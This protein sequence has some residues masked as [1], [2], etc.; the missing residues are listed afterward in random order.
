M[1]LDN[2]E[3]AKLKEL[4][5]SCIWHPCTQMHDHEANIPLIPIA[6]AQG[7]YLYDFENRAYLDCVSSWWVN[8]F[9]H[10]NPYISAKL[11]EQLD[12]LEHIIL[13]VSRTSPL[14]NY[15]TDFWSF[16]ILNSASVSMPIMAQVRLKLHSKWRSTL[17]RFKRKR[18]INLYA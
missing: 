6:R 7:V 15:P 11:K 4:D 2:T 17:V 10:C 13:Q 3:S 18:K 9:G 16:W 12:S 1:T 14:L 5:L 8:L